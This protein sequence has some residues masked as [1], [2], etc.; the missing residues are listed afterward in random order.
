MA[1]TTEH[2]EQIIKRAATDPN[3][4]QALTANPAA[5]FTAHE[6]DIPA[7]AH[8]DF[9][10]FIGQQADGGDAVLLASF[11]GC[12][13]C[14]IGCYAIAATIVGVGVGG[15]ATLGTGSVVVVA[16]AAFAAV[17]AATALAFIQSLNT[18]VGSGANAVAEQ[19]C[20]WTHACS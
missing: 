12:L 10:A 1:N 16:L 14:K 19:I 17:S 6:V 4:G 15:I 20:K 3:M 2:V 18:V 7:E 5:F 13:A 8:D 9:N 11:G